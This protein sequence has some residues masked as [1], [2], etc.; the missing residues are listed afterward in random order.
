MKKELINLIK[1]ALNSDSNKK[2][3]II[4]GSVTNKE[5]LILKKISMVDLNN[6]IRI[7]DNYMIRHTI[8]KHGNTYVEE[9]RGQVAITPNDFLLIPE[10][11]HNADKIEHIGKNNLKQDL[12]RYTKKNDY[13]Y[14][15]IEAIR[16]S[17]KGTKMVFTTMYKK[18][19]RINQ[20]E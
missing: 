19:E 14:V 13:L 2:K 17:N 4:I 1:D 20:G 10:I 3:E 15:V 7:I 9:K 16:I 11:I 12:I 18:N 5:A 8:K 6:C